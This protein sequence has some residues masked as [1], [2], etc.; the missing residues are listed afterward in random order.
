MLFAAAEGTVVA[1]RA[2]SNEVLEQTGARGGESLV[3]R[4]VYPVWINCRQFVHIRKRIAVSPGMYGLMFQGVADQSLL[5]SEPRWRLSSNS[6]RKRSRHE[7][8]SRKPT[9]MS[10]P[11]AGA[12]FGSRRTAAFNNIETGASSDASMPLAA[13][14]RSSSKGIALPAAGI[15]KKRACRPAAIKRPATR[16]Q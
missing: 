9:S 7:I 12:R 15:Q 6:V 10:W 8:L 1:K 2:A 5:S 3:L 11:R 14:D 16:R 4:Q 13:S